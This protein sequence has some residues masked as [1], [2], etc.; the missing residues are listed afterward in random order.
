MNLPRG[1]RPRITPLVQVIRGFRLGHAAAPNAWEDLGEQDA[2]ENAHRRRNE[3]QAGTRRRQPEQA[4]AG[5]FDRDREEHG[6]EA[7]EHPDEDRQH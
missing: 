7:G 3:Q 5:L 4:V 1:T 2:R 6:R